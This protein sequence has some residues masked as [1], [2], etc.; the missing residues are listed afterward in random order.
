MDNAVVKQILDRIIPVYHPKAVY[1][2]GSRAWGEPSA[3]SD[4]DLFV[5]LEASFDSQA[6][7]IRQGARALMGT[8]LDVDLLVL[9]EAEIAVRRTQ[10]T[11]LTYL[12]LEKGIR[13]YAA[14]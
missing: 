8:G 10:K 5:I 9:T 13:L 6:E 3:D 14:A 1:L 7:R 11:S 2:Y 4:I 12:V